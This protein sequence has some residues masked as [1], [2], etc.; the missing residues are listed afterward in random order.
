MADYNVTDEH[1]LA[2]ALIASVSPVEAE[3][4][5]QA[6]PEEMAWESYR[7]AVTKVYPAVPYQDFCGA[8]GSAQVET[9]L[10]IPYE[11]DATKVVQIQLM[12]AGVR[13]AA[14]LESALGER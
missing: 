12:K 14:L 1:A 10:S 4:W 9:D 3:K 2:A 11:E 6:T 7:I 8:E 13:L 5:T